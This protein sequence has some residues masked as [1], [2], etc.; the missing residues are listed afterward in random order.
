[1]PLD[2]PRVVGSKW[3]ERSR[4]APHAEG[5]TLVDAAHERDQTS[6]ASVWPPHG[7]Q[8]RQWGACWRRQV[9]YI[10][11]ASGPVFAHWR[12]DFFRNYPR[13]VVGAWV[14]SPLYKEGAR[15]TARLAESQGWGSTKFDNDFVTVENPGNKPN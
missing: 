6:A 14:F 3:D 8:G 13:G 15:V 5:S 4:N 1:M 12:P 11:G 2:N 7:A 9:L 10:E